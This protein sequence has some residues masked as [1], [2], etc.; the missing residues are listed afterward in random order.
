MHQFPNFGIIPV[1]TVYIQDMLS[2]IEKLTRCHIYALNRM[3]RFAF[4]EHI[5]FCNEDR[6][7]IRQFVKVLACV[8]VFHI[9]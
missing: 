5:M 9:H 6:I 2:V 8:K 3:K 4:T 1:L 7:G